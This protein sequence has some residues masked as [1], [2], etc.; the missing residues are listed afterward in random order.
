MTTSIPHA[1]TVIVNG[2]PAV[3]ILPKDYILS[4]LRQDAE[5]LRDLLAEGNRASGEVPVWRRNV[6]AARQA[7]AAFGAT[8]AEIESATAALLRP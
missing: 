2:E 1:A 7:A 3:G 8:A 6:D 4:E 5:T